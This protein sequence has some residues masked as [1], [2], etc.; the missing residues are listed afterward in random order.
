M[1]NKKEDDRKRPWKEKHIYA[2]AHLEKEY[3]SSFRL[4]STCI[5]YHGIR[6]G[7]GERIAA[8]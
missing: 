7:K 8:N 5:Y 2:V 3:K 4:K 6:T 1:A